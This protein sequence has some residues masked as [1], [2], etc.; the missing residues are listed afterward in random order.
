MRGRLARIVVIGALA[1]AGWACGSSATTDAP[2]DD[3]GTDA[4]TNDA[5]ALPALDAAPVEAS[6]DSAVPPLDTL[7][8]NRDRLLGTYLAHLKATPGKQSNGL[9]GSKLAGVCELW[10][11]LVPSAQGVYLTLTAR[12]QG[13]RLR[14][15]ASS[16]LFHTT[17]LYRVAGGDGATTSDPGACGGDG[18]RMFL[19]VDETLHHSL[20]VAN[21]SKGLAP[22][23]RRDRAGRRA[24]RRGELLA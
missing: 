24:R 1:A 8:A 16:M 3:G 9:D 23:R 7:P 21:S 20:L 10:R 15:D 4:G 17:R 2:G 12:L 13:S 18:N 11:A 14:V 19:S 6:L 5:D 22:G